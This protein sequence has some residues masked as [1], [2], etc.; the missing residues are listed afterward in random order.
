MKPNKTELASDGKDF[1]FSKTSSIQQ[2]LN[3]VPIP[4]FSFNKKGIISFTNKAFTEL[5]EKTISPGTSVLKIKLKYEN[6]ADQKSSAKETPLSA[7]LNSE[8]PVSNVQVLFGSAKRNF[9]L[10]SSFLTEG[11]QETDEIQ[12]CLVPTYS[13]EVEEIKNARLSAIVESSNDA[14]ISKDL[15]GYIKTWNKG[16]Q[17][18][19]KYS[20]EEMIGKHVSVLFPEDKLNDELMILETI[21]RGEQ[22]K[23]FDTIRLDKYGNEIPLSLTISPIK[24]SQGKIIG[25]SK[26]ARDISERLKAEKKQA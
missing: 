18:I 9:L 7:V 17:E 16:A 23:H 25:A 6:P 4:I 13:A 20:E 12:C 11:N 5:N 22:I 14:I 26:V 8:K 19:F 2:M 1:S 24:N 15:N 21:R 3:N 10:N